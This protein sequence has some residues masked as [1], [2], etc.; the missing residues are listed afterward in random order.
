MF[1]GPG[2]FVPRRSLKNSLKEIY[3]PSGTT[4]HASN[5]PFGIVGCGGTQPAIP[6]TS[7]TAYP[8]AGRLGCL[9]KSSSTLTVISPIALHGTIHRR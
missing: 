2:L 8:T 3:F 7:R 6:A 4:G 9:P 5:G 1:L